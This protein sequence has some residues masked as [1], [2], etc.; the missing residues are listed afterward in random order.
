MYATWWQ[1]EDHT[2]ALQYVWPEILLSWFVN[3]S[4]RD[5]IPRVFAMNQIFSTMITNVDGYL[6]KEPEFAMH[7]A[8]LAKLR[9]DTKRFLACGTFLDNRGLRVE[10]GVGHVYTS[11]S[12]LAVAVG[13]KLEK[14]CKVQ[15]E[16]TPEI[17]GLKPNKKGLIYIE[18]I[19]EVE[20]EAKESDGLLTME[21]A[22][23]A[24]GSGVW[25]IPNV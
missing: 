25:C 14:G 13:N 15:I 8:R 5:V 2:E 9:Q 11:S 7:I 6:S 24:Y 20:V 4:D 16:L 1:P 10:G 22:L 17:L 19:S 12:G 21:I 18:G 3:E 23:P